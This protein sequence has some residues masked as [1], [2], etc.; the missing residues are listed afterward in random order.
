MICKKCNLRTEIDFIRCPVCYSLSGPG[1]I[2]DLA[3]RIGFW[4]RDRRL[5]L[6]S[7]R[8]GFDKFLYQHDLL[9]DSCLGMYRN[10]WTYRLFDLIPIAKIQDGQAVFVY[11]PVQWNRPPKP[12]D[13]SGTGSTVPN[14]TMS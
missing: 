3:R 12:V 9:V 13:S 4:I 2:L 14:N 5:C 6:I 1:Y 8:C 11:K 10:W 7:K